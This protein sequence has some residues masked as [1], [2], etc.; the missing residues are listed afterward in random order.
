ML[1]LNDIA[2]HHTGEGKLYLCAVKDVFSNRIVGYSIDSRM[3]ARLAVDAL[4]FAAVRRTAVGDQVA[5][6]I[7]HSDRGS[8][9]RSRKFFAPWVSTQWSDPWDE[10]APAVTMRRWN[11]FLR[12]YRKTSSTGSLG[13]PATSCDRDSHLDRTDLPPASAP[14]QA[15][16]I[17]PGRIRSHHDHTSSSSC[18]IAVT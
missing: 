11:R 9:F 7:V 12:C 6:C 10:S 1:W 14:G 3:K 13:R 18:L 17:D 16:Q 4:A 8:Q 2:E 5:G 15:Q